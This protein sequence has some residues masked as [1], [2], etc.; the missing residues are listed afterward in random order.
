MTL[1]WV[2]GAAVNAEK[3]RLPFSQSPLTAR[4]RY[5]KVFPNHKQDT[6]SAACPE[7]ASGPS[8]STTCPKH[9]ICHLLMLRTRRLNLGESPPAFEGS[10]FLPFVAV[11]FLLVTTKHLRPTVKVETFLFCFLLLSIP[12]F[13]FIDGDEKSKVN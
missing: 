12:T 6:I 3:P 8:L 13:Y 10:S 5:I 2:T 9:L 11:I 4:P 1:V 7:S